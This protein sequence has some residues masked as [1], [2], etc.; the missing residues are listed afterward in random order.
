MTFKRPACLFRLPIWV[1]V[2][3]NSYDLVPVSTFG[4][5]VEQPEISPTVG[6]VVRG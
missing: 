5:G 1:D 6:V 3:H 2:Q 4:V